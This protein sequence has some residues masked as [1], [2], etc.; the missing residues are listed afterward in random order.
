MKQPAL[1]ETFDRREVEWEQQRLN[2]LEKMRA[3]FIKS[4]SVAEI[5]TSNY[6]GLQKP[7]S[8]EFNLE[9]SDIEIAPPLIKAPS[10]VASV[11]GPPA[12]GPPAKGPPKKL[13][14]ETIFESEA[15]A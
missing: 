10:K 13:E 6:H 7:L 8:R 11:R 14:L 3:E 15:T 4:P 2:T 9:L 1:P 5:A 12:K